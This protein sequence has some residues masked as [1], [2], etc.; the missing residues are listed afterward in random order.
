MRRNLAYYRQRLEVLRLQVQ[1]HA[2]IEHARELSL[3]GHQRQADW[4]LEIAASSRRRAA[5]AQRQARDAAYFSENS[6][7]LGFAAKILDERMTPGQ[8]LTAYGSQPQHVFEAGM[9]AANWAIGMT[10]IKP[11]EALK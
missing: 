2:Q 10:A 9:A 1:A 5:D 3:S 4:M 11:S 6:R 7:P 8:V